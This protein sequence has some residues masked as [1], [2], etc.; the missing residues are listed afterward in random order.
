MFAFILLVLN[1]LPF[2]HFIKLVNGDE[3]E[4][5]SENTR[6]YGDTVYYFSDVAMAF[7]EA[8]AS[9]KTV[10]GT[11]RRWSS[12]LAVMR[13]QTDLDNVKSIYSGSLST[14]LFSFVF[15]D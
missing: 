7:E 3:A 15:D 11:T 2:W 12:H 5:L 6:D 1:F 14:P 8:Q 13:N 9:C 4:G 10:F